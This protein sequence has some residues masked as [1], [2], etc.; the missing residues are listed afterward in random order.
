MRV[1]DH[2]TGRSPQIRRLYRSVLAAVR[3]IGPVRVD[4][5]GRGIAFQVRARSIG[6]MFRRDWIDLGL[7]LKRPIRDR[8]AQRIEDFGAL[9]RVYHFR[10]RRPDDLDLSLLRLVR[11][12]YAVG[13]QE[14]PTI[15]RPQGNARRRAG[16]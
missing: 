8:R 7:W 16:A 1:S 6:V 3:S 13:A 9:G 15:R 4:P 2:L 10:I 14:I 11:K 12:A 5:Q